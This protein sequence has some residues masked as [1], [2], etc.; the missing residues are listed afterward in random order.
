MPDIID[1]Y[2]AP[3]SGY[4]YLGEP[5]LVDL[6]T[7]TGAEIRFKPIDIGRVFAESETVPPFKQSAARLGYRLLDL[8]R[9]ADYLNLPINP[10]PRY[11]PVPV[12]LAARSIYA[13]IQAGGDAHSLSFAILS[14]VYAEERDV[15]DEQVIRDIF[16]ALGLDTE[17]LW[18]ALWSERV[19]N[20]YEQATQ[21][22]INLGVFGS[23][24]YVLNR[25]E[26]FFGQD[27]I[28][29][30]EHY[31]WKKGQKRVMDTDFT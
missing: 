14:A 21:E 10:R 5:R 3:I 30:L 6:A 1:Y 7:R 26:M 13:A 16:D 15:S 17:V 12:E 23:P 11:W 2:Y 8:Q 24:T 25:E 9:T 18:G 22:A 28:E 27:R 19:S 4:A 31:L 20:A 29:L